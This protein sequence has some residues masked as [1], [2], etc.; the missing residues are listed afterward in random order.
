[1]L[2]FHTHIL[3]THPAVCFDWAPLSSLQGILG[4]FSPTEVFA[5]ENG[6]LFFYQDENFFLA[7]GERVGFYVSSLPSVSK[8]IC[9]LGFVL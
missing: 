7:F 1:M 2:D 6:T 9:W 4:L 8:G 3:F 5:C